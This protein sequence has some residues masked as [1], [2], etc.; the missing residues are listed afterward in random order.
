M[1][2]DDLELYWDATYAVATA[3]MES[4]PEVDPAGVGLEELEQMVERLPNFVDDPALVNER[5][6]LDIQITWYE[7]ATR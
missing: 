2:Q 1:S 7:E 3:L 6:L 5:I 4:H